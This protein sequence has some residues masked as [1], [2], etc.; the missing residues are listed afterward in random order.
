MRGEGQRIVPAGRGDHALTVGRLS[1]RC[2]QR[3]AHVHGETATK[4]E[5]PWRQTWQLYIDGHWVGT[6]SGKTFA[7]VN[8][9][10]QDVIAQVPDGGPAQA[11][12]AVKA[13]AGAFGSWSRLPRME[14]GRLL[15]KTHQ[16]MI[17]R[18]DDL[19]RLV[20]QE[21][22]KPWDEARKEVAF[23]AG[24]FQLVC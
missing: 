19:A 8:P 20:T 5:A 12:A 22:G 16:L 17:E 4:G 1:A 21:N 3:L 14:R 18:C 2:V 7:V 15:A 13:A 23:A 9:A 10:T 24:Y 6:Q 11:H